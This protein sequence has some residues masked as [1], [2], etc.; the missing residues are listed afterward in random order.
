MSP[1]TLGHKR[2]LLF[3]LGGLVAVIVVWLVMEWWV[4]PTTAGERIDMATA[5]FG[6]L[7]ASLL[8]L[9]AWN[10]YGT[11]RNS[12]LTLDQTRETQFA[13]RFAKAIEQLG[14]AESEIRIGAIYSLESLSR[15]SE[16]HYQPC[17]D[18]L[19]Y[20]IRRFQ[21]MTHDV[22]TRIRTGELS[23]VVR[24]DV[25]TA[26]LVLGRTRMPEAVTSVRRLDFSNL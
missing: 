9:G 23:P 25:Q 5:V 22:E 16:S 8:L 2:V 21:M 7:G 12:R 17:V 4:E 20:F 24:P 18:V 13:E 1:G 10:T 15:Q 19:N 3:C 6:A 14:H 11:V 26:I